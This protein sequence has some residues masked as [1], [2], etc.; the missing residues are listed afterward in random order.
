[1]LGAVVLPLASG[2]GCHD[3]LL[4]VAVIFNVD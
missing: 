4:T 1:M 3:E 2:I